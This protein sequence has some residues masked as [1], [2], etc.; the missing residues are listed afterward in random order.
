MTMC[1]ILAAFSGAVPDGGME[2]TEQS[3]NVRADGD[4]I[5]E[6]Q[7][8]KGVPQQLQCAHRGRKIPDRF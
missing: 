8:K 1:E 6:S 2:Y 7:T 3:L 5:T 4:H